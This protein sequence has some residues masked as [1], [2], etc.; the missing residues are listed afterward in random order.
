MFM[1]IFKT[2]LFLIFTFA[3]T[4]G[5]AQD[6]HYSLFNMS[7]M[8]MNPALTGAFSGTARIGGL[9]RNQAFSIN[10]LQEYNTPSVYVDAPILQGFKKGDWIGVGLVFVSDKVGILEFTTNRI[11]LSASYHLALN[12]K[13]T[14]VLTLGLQGG[15]VSR[16]FSP[17]MTG[18]RLSELFEISQGGLGNTAPSDQALMSV[19]DTT[20][21]YTDYSGGLM[22]RTQL[23][24]TADLEVGFSAGHISKPVYVFA[25]N[26]GSQEQ[27]KLP[28]RLSAHAKLEMPLQ[29]KWSIAPTVYWQG[30]AGANEIILQGWGGYQLNKDVKLNFGLGYRFGD[31]LNVLLGADFKENLRVALAYDVTLSELSNVNSYSGGVEIAAWYIIKKYKQPVIKPKVLCPRF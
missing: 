24:K 9:Y 17:D 30:E 21:S 3:L 20:T 10:D 18:V 4:D 11:E 28:M 15:S 23:N 27:N 12:K 6:I 29:G 14:S 25:T 16:S 7:P 22:L 26:A 31:A 1:K 19:I 5:N 8:T 2:L 13:G